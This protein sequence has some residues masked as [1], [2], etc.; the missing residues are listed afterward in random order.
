MNSSFDNRKEKIA[1]LT[2]K[3]KELMAN[4]EATDSKVKLAATK[5]E[6]KKT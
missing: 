1:E 3:N 4:L 5:V 2:N 6:V